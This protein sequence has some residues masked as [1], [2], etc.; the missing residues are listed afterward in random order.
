[1]RSQDSAERSW[2]KVSRFCYMLMKYSCDRRPTPP[3]RNGSLCWWSIP[4]W[5]T[6]YGFIITR[7]PWSTGDQSSSMHMWLQTTKSS[8]DENVQCVHVHSCMRQSCMQSSKSAAPPPSRCS[9]LQQP[10]QI[11][12]AVWFWSCVVLH[13]AARPAAARAAL[14]TGHPVRPAPAA[15]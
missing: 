15:P 13:S 2:F 7:R 11:W 6:N 10:S 5:P 8:G 14:A 1:M 12:S 9:A 4:P 3:K